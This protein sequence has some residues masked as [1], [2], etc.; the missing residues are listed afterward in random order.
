MPSTGDTT[1]TAT[2]PGGATESYVVAAADAATLVKGDVVVKFKGKTAGTSEAAHDIEL[3][4]AQY[5]KIEYVV[6]P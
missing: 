6:T 2:L 3:T 4:R 5:R 1:I